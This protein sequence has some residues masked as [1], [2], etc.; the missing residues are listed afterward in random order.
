MRTRSVR[1]MQLR[2]CHY[3]RALPMRSEALVPSRS[4]RY[5]QAYRCERE[6]R[7]HR[8]RRDTSKRNDA[9]EK[10]RAPFQ[11]KASIQSIQSRPLRRERVRRCERA[12]VGTIESIVVQRSAGIRTIMLS[13]IGVNEHVD[14]N[15]DMTRRCERPCRCEQEVCG[16][17]VNTI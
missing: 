12:C 4:L 14:T 11:A 1:L 10:S 3:D 17:S 16:W 13:T 5:E 2:E 15:V 7:Y 9:I 6:H 8:D